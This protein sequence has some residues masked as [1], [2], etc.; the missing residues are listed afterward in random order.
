[1]TEDIS[2]VGKFD[3]AQDPRQLEELNQWIQKMQNRMNQ[4]DPGSFSLAWI[5]GAA[6]GQVIASMGV[7]VAPVWN[8]SPTLTGLTLNGLSASALVAT[9]ASKQLVSDTNSYML[10]GGSGGGGGGTPATYKITISDTEP[11]A[12]RNV[13]DLWVQIITP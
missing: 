4:F 7:G 6:A 1:M 10:A 2:F 5:A 12:P 8:D 13:G 11:P 9:N 3:D